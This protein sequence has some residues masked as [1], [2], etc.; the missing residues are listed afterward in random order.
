MVF[1]LEIFIKAVNVRIKMTV[2]YKET[3]T[4]KP[5]LNIVIDYFLN[6]AIEQSQDKSDISD[7]L[8]I[9]NIN[10]INPDDKDLNTQT[11]ITLEL[12]EVC[13]RLTNS[14]GQP[15]LEML[16]P[17]ANVYVKPEQDYYL[18]TG[19]IKTKKQESGLDQCLEGF[20]SFAIGLEIVEYSPY[21][22]IM[23]LKNIFFDQYKGE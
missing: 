10:L 4:L 18:I 21:N 2:N 11:E 19:V 14:Y 9:S 22:V 3:P 6:K 1:I 16:S 23:R 13:L 7:Q 17:K 8:D 20:K 5:T 15:Q 12:G